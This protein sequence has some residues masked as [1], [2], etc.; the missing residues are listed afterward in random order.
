MPKQP[1]DDSSSRAAKRQFRAKI[2]MPEQPT[3]YDDSPGAAKQ[4]SSWLLRLGGVSVLAMINLICSRQGMQYISIV[5]PH[6]N[7]KHYHEESEDEINRLLDVGQG[8]LQKMMS[9]D[10][11]DASFSSPTFETFHDFNLSGPRPQPF[12][13]GLSLAELTT[14]AHSKSSASRSLGFDGAKHGA[15]HASFAG[16]HQID[17]DKY[18][19]AAWL[20][21]T[22][23]LLQNREVGEHKIQ[24]GFRNLET[25]FFI[26]TRNAKE[27]VVTVDLFDFYVQHLS[28]FRK[29]LEG[30]DPI[31]DAA[32]LAR[33]KIME[34]DC[35]RTGI[36]YNNPTQERNG[37]VLAVLPFYNSPQPN[38]EG[39]ITAGSVDRQLFLNLTVFTTSNIFPNLAVFVATQ[40]DYDYVVYQSG[41]NQYLY[42]VVLLADLREPTHLTLG[43]VVRTKSFFLNQTYDSSIFEYVYYSETDQLPYLRNV[44]ALLAQAS[45]E[46]SLVIPHRGQAYPVTQDY[47]NDTLQTFSKLSVKT[48]EQNALSEEHF[49]P[50]MM[51]AR[52]CFPL[53][54]DATAKF[55]LREHPSQLKRFRHRESS[56]A[57]IAGTGNYFEHAYNPCNLSMTILSPS[58]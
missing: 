1:T 12:R 21:S 58:C 11:S 13:A 6:D 15:A 17:S 20:S 35:R 46:S 55:S 52:C 4:Q 39:K 33:N 27:A 5:S 9:D 7:A 38:A 29:L 8:G 10:D 28:T 51:Q 50:D 49:I 48:M 47:T 30:N 44:R 14:L 18:Y 53:K 19:A 54:P 26:P 37:N 40:A 36:A 22:Q 34:S 2:G 3:T 41:L 57:F 42:D 16:F 32:L 23:T 24:T 45:K 43:S 31:R 56:F 25:G